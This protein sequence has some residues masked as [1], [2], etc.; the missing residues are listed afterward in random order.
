MVLD[1]T[2]DAIVEHPLPRAHRQP[3]AQRVQAK[4]AR[5]GRGARVAPLGNDAELLASQLR[6]ALPDTAAGNSGF[7]AECEEYAGRA[8]VHVY[9]YKHSRMVV[10]ACKV[11]ES[12]SETVN[13]AAIAASREAQPLVEGVGDMQPFVFKEDVYI[14]MFDDSEARFFYY[15]VSTG[16]STWRRPAVYIPYTLMGDEASDPATAAG[17]SGDAK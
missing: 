9:G 14:E 3:T 12:V 1:G 4:G 7:C 10:S 11:E 13:H 5:E 6:A 8:L 2:I 17:A 15:N 16:L